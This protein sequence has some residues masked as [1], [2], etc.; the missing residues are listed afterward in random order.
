MRN[1]QNLAAGINVTPL[2]NQLYRHPELWNQHRIRTEHEQSPHSQCD[3]ILLRFQSGN[4]VEVVDDPECIW[5]PAWEVLTELHSILFNLCRTVCAERIGRILISRL[6]PGK[7]ITPHEDGGA[8]A[9]YYTRYQLLLQS[10]AGCVF[11]CD[12]ERVQMAS[13]QL[14]WFDNRKTHSVT[15]NSATDRISVIIDLKTK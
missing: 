7:V 5:Y 14:W 2:L 12:G 9:T 8:V 1:F 11:D 15:N 13:G 4:G 3:D 10:E 6:A